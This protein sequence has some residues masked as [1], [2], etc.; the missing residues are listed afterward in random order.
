MNFNI[1][2]PALVVGR[3]VTADDFFDHLHRLQLGDD[4]WASRLGFDTET[5]GINVVYDVPV[6]ASIS[7]GESRWLMSL[8]HL[9]DPRFEALIVDR[10][11]HWTMAN[12]KFDMHMC[13]NVGLP[14]FRGPIFDII[15]AC[16]L[17]DENRKG[18]AGLGLKEQSRDYLGITM[19]SFRDTFS[20]RVKKGDEGR[21]LLDADID[22]VAGY[23]SL[24]AYATWLL[25]ADH[26]VA[27]GGASI[28][29]NLMG[30]AH[31]LDY[32]WALEVPFTK[33]L[34]RMERRGVCVDADY[35][36]ALRAPMNEKRDAALG[37]VLRIAGR[38]I[39][40]ASPKQLGEI[41]YSPKSEGGLGIKPRKWTA[42]GQPSTDEGTLIKL[43]STVPIAKCILEWRK[44]AKLISTYIDGMLGQVT[45]AGRVHATFN[46][47]GTVT[48]R[49]S[50]KKPSLQNIQ[51]QG[52]NGKA[53]RSAF[54]APSGCSLV[55]A[56]YAQME[57]CVM[58][59]V[60]DSSSMINSISSGQDLHSFTASSM[61]NVEYDHV[62]LAKR[63]SDLEIGEEETDEE[64][65]GRRLATVEEFQVYN[66]DAVN[67]LNR[68]DDGYAGEL[69]AARRAAK[70]I[71]FGLMYGMGPGALSD[72][73][74][75]SR[76]EAK[77]LTAAWFDTF[78]AVK[79]YIERIQREAETSEDHAVYTVFGRPRRLT[80]ITSSN[81]GVRSQAKRYAIN[82]PIQGSAACLMKYAM[83]LI[84]L[85]P[86]LGG[87]CLEGGSLGTQL[88]LQV[89]DEIMMSVPNSS[90]ERYVNERM[91]RFMVTV[92]PAL[93]VPLKATG[94]AA[95]NWGAAK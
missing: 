18:G 78:P 8:E 67:L 22:L 2:P 16:A 83:I 66:L 9:T 87:D 58:A 56:D 10:D 11:V 55:V 62:L 82:A 61:L 39:N 32:M 91:Q 26:C 21:A 93:R 90:D 68:L 60:A 38:P 64:F 12:A 75:V 20:L 73:L 4:P 42:S 14:E 89:H 85:D 36:N 57:M 59:H 30:F 63:L 51:A 80:G 23:A 52:E 71:G 84:D 43:Q 46:Q 47:A 86:E 37:E 28:P 3:D 76:K 5:T 7:D 69:L 77:D 31:L 49:L 19:R 70:A 13:A 24:D 50:V 34:W 27:L 35:L 54:V 95:P 41:L 88:L 45:P 6:F 72:E 81:N 65:Q 74:G 17:R 29:P 94:G 33:T 25:S 92:A 48:G 40:P 79:D 15:V 44:L 53:I 1:L